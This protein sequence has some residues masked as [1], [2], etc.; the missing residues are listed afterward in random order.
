[1]SIKVRRHFDL[2]LRFTW[3]HPA[4]HVH[5]SAIRCKEQDR[6]LRDIVLGDLQA[7][8]EA[9]RASNRKSIIRK[10]NGGRAQTWKSELEKDPRVTAG[11]A[12]KHGPQPALEEASPDG[13]EVVR[14]HFSVWRVKDGVE[15]A[16]PKGASENSA[17]RLYRKLT[18]AKQRS[19]AL[20][21]KRI[22]PTL[23]EMGRYVN[24]PPSFRVKNQLNFKPWE[25]AS[26]RAETDKTKRCVDL[27]GADIDILTNTQIQPRASDTWRMVDTHTSG[28]VIQARPTPCYHRSNEAK[29]HRCRVL[30]IWIL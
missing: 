5:S 6:Q 8:L 20:K 21:S 14:K 18:V 15:S 10:I 12:E 22:D 27:R 3:N 30:C 7:T 16:V 19:A 1:M 2:A 11:V 13:E 26:S 23:F 17:K 25:S 9:H 4:R 29:G 24:L 28:K